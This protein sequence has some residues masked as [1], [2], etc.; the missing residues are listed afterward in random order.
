MRIIERLDKYIKFNELNDNQI[1]VNC[2]LSVGLL[3]KARKGDSD[4]GKKAIDK[5]LNFYQDINKT[6]LLTGEG[7]MLKSPQMNEAK[8]I[9]VDM[10]MHIPLVP[11]T[12]QGGY[13]RG[14]GD[15][16]YIDSLPSIPVIVDKTYKGKYRVFEVEGDSMDDG[17]RYALYDGD[18]I[19]CREVKRELWKSKLHIRDWFFVV[20]HQYEG[21]TVKQIINHN[22]ENGDIV[23]HPLNPIFDDFSLNLDDVTELYNVI[24]IVDRNTRI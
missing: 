10:F 16:E 12:A 22:V 8:A 9:D 21:I 24:K 17:S 5:I 23:C 18:K 14:Y 15:Q 6:W 11:V 4:L 20:V 7:S 1:T 2:E 13:L 3:G 19:L